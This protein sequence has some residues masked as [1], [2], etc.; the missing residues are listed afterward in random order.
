MSHGYSTVQLIAA[1]I[2]GFTTVELISGSIG[3]HRI[4]QT[5]LMEAGMITTLLAYISLIVSTLTPKPLEALLLMREEDQ[6]KTAALQ[7][8][9]GITLILI[10]GLIMLSLFS[11]RHAILFFSGFV[12]LLM[13]RVVKERHAHFVRTTLIEAKVGASDTD[14]EEISW[15]F[16]LDRSLLEHVVQGI[17]V[18]TKP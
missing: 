7:L 9:L 14:M 4:I 5:S 10:T 16:G 15:R 18:R 8:F 11:W 1:P 6:K 2:I 17:E 12:L 3:D 13:D